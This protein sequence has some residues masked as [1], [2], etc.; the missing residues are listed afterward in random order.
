[1]SPQRQHPLDKKV[2]P[3]WKPPASLAE[4]KPGMLLSD[5]IWHW[6]VSLAGLGIVGC[7]VAVMAFLHLGR[8]GGLVAGVGLAVFITGFPSQAQHNGYR[9]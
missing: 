3:N 4:R 5:R 2:S 9:E 7:G 8:W 1:M 6:L